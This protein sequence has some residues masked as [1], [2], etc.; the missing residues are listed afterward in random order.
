MAKNIKKQVASEKQ[1]SY[2]Q[3]DF[4]SFRQE[5]LLYA[6]KHYSDKIVDFSEA[7]LAGLF[8]DMASYVGDSLSFYLDHQYTENFL[9]T[10]SEVENLTML[11]RNT[12]IDIPGPSPS[13]A[14]VDISLI[15]PATRQADTSNFIPNEFFMPVIKEGTIFGTRNGIEFTLLDDVNFAK[16]DVNGNLIADYQI[17]SRNSSGDVIDFIV[18]LKGNCTSASTHTE[19]IPI[20]SQFIPFRSLTLEKED[21][22]EIISVLDTD[23]DEYY[24]VKS[25]TQDTVFKRFENSRSDYELVPERIELI[26]A[27]KRF[28]SLRSTST[29][30]TTIKF[31]SGN[32][33]RFDEDI[34][35]DPSEHAI[36]LYGDRK[37]FNSLTIDPNSFL[38]TS[39]LGISPRN[40]NLTIKYRHGGGLSHNV[41]AGQIVFVQTLITKFNSSVSSFYVNKIRSSLSVINESSSTGGENE[42]SIENLR[43]IALL[44]KNS[45]DRIVTREDLLSRVYSMP[46]NLGR[47]FRVSVRD[48][49]NNPLAAQMHVISRNKNKKLILSSDTLKENLAIYLSQ[50][51][52]ISDAIDVI[53]A[54]VI[55]LAIDIEVTVE[56]K[57]NKSSVCQQVVNS[58]KKYMNTENFQID[59]P[60]ILGEI[61]NLILNTPGVM[62]IIDLKFNN[63]NN[64]F[65]NR[66]YS[67]S[68]YSISRA[69]DRGLIFPPRG[70][71]FEVRY[72]L[73]DIKCK[74]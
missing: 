2:I 44:S 29:G 48:N 33:E 23:L 68:R 61:E 3:K 32:A 36:K 26:P 38:E 50:F 56:K 59:Q 12:G 64:F 53:D 22:T 37:T 25:L 5:L 41:T 72:P 21:I 49:P 58:I 66:V 39:T 73:D 31:G 18:T 10:A 74:A 24:Q 42:P 1:F 71:I 46:S 40:T 60:I 67:A 62:S 8:L 45:Q 13:I 43:Q 65:Q 51:R 4:S 11:I 69:I 28:I 57:F 17:N 63:R 27:P 20:G 47:V 19:L 55:N 54:Q 15:I 16:K 30:K 9:E 6:R 14:I 52:L 34:V 70:G 7:S 35:P